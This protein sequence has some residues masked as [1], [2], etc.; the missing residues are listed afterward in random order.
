MKTIEDV[1]GYLLLALQECD[2]LYEEN[3][4]DDQVIA[5]LE[6]AI[7]EA[8]GEVAQI[9]LKRADQREG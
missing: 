9:K 5:K 1:K 6:H 2:N 8:L 7:E 4:D 3:K